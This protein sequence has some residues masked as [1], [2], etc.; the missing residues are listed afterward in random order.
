MISKEVEQIRFEWRYSLQSSGKL[1]DSQSLFFTQNG[2]RSLLCA[3]CWS[4]ILILEIAAADLF[5]QSKHLCWPSVISQ[6]GQA[7]G[8]AGSTRLAGQ[9]NRRSTALVISQS[10]VACQWLEWASS[11][12]W[13]QQSSMVI[14]VVQWWVWHWH[15]S[16]ESCRSAATQ[17]PSL[18]VR[19]LFT[20]S[21]W[22]RQPPDVARKVWFST[23]PS[24]P[25]TGS[26]PARFVMWFVEQKVPVYI[27]NTVSFS[28]INTKSATLF[29]HRL[30][31]LS[32]E[33]I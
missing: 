30:S 2:K 3:T 24:L 33:F 15:R 17:S 31:V 4:R 9:S 14:V 8:T 27:V 23:E 6:R 26:Q 18:S 12:Q 5:L 21:L 28:N 22:L 16:E 1:L 13:L 20:R 7:T 29:V 32:F 19:L 25:E 10:A 11:Q